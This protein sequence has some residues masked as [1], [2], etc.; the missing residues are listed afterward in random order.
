LVNSVFGAFE[1]DVPEIS[2]G[3]TASLLKAFTGFSKGLSK[4]KKPSKKT[5]D[6]NAPKKPVNTYFAW[7][8][9]NRSTLKEQNGG[10]EEGLSDLLKSEYEKFKKSAAFEKM[11]KD[12]EEK[13]HAYKDE[14]KDYVSEESSEDEDGKKTKGKKTTTKKAKKVEKSPEEKQPPNVYMAFRKMKLDTIKAGLSEGANLAEALK[15]S[16]EEFKKTAEY[17]TLQDKCKADFATWKETS[18]E[19]KGDVKA[20]VKGSDESD[21]DEAPSKVETKKAEV[22]KAAPKKADAKKVAKPVD[23]DDDDDTFTMPTEK[24]TKAK[25]TT[26]KDDKKKKTTKKAEVTSDSEDDE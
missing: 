8:A 19:V 12:C 4:E 6:P 21:S 24:K 2:K 10:V 22:K 25:T 13:M 20:D 1:I 23:S 3:V 17:K 15:E 16:Y 18:K 9:S 7:L 5:K 26:K 14:M 11:Q